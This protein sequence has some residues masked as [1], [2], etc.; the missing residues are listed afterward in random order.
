MQVVVI[1]IL[2]FFASWGIV[3][4]IGL[5]CAPSRLESDARSA[6]QSELALLGDK[7]AKVQAHV[8]EPVVPIKEQENRSVVCALIA[9]AGDDEIAV[10]K[11][12]CDRDEIFATHLYELGDRDAISNSIG[13]WRHKLIHERVERDS[14]ATYWSIVPGLKDALVYVLYEQ[15][16]KP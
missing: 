12:L 15:L 4:F 11:I 6:H 8:K 14:N 13:K 2:G 16:P 7:L 5:I 3:F 9:N 1:S 10:L